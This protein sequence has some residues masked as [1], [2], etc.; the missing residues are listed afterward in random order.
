M[1]KQPGLI[2]LDLHLW[3]IQF[4]CLT[5]DDNIGPKLKKPNFVLSGLCWS[6]S[7]FIDIVRKILCVWRAPDGWSEYTTTQ[8]TRAGRNI[9]KGM[10]DPIIISYKLTMCLY[11]YLK[12]TYNTL[13]NTFTISCLNQASIHGYRAVN[14]TK[15]SSRSR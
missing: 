13:W 12:N 9:Q 15:D 7:N 14:F 4:N 11:L 6:W 1:I 3:V 8:Q 10:L 5:Y 2:F